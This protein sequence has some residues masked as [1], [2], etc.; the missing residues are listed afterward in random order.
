MTIQS[1][2]SKKRTFEEWVYTIDF[3]IKNNEKTR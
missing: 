2:L 1:V 3:I